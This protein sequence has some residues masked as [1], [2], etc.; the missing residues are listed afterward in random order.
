MNFPQLDLLL[1]AAYFGKLSGDSPELMPLD[2]SLEKDYGNSAK[3]HL[4]ISM[5]LSWTKNNKDLRKSSLATPR[6]VKSIE[7]RRG[8]GEHQ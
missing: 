2:S 5:H 3:R 8:K 4:A 6:E 7:T 1:G